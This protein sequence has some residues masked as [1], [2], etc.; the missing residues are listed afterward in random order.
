MSPM[1]PDKVRL[2]LE[3]LEGAPPW[4]ELRRQMVAFCERS[5]A[6]LSDELC[7]YPTGTQDWEI[8]SGAIE[9]CGEV[10]P[11]LEDASD[12]AAAWAG[13]SDAAGSIPL[14]ASRSKRNRERGRSVMSMQIAIRI[15]TG[16]VIELDIPGDLPLATPA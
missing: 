6:A 13:N 9:Y 5:R 7:R 4:D 3:Q 8:L 10:I 15:Q 1:D 16:H 14:W 11:V 12:W 2:R